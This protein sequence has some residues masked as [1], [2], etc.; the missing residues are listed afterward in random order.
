RL[1]PLCRTVEDCAIVFQVIA[2][3]DEQDLSVIDLPFNWDADLDITKLRVGYL[4]PAFREPNRSEELK[5]SDQQALDQLRKM[6]VKLE[7]FE[8]PRMPTNVTGGFGAESGAS[9]DEFVRS[10]RDKNMTS[11]T[12]GNGFRSSRLLPAV[13]YL[14]G[15]RVRAM[16]MRQM[17]EV[18]SKFDVYVAPFANT[19]GG[20]GGAGRSTT[21][22]AA[23]E[24]G[25][26]EAGRSGQGRSTS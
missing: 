11:R 25:R 14:Q 4:E 8:L 16:V 12:R 21:A 18:V 2:K 26:G 24:A 19:R 1:G 3:P 6:G 10:G 5:K 23:D 22:E 7:P 9:F 20:P 17:A 15:Q 13:E